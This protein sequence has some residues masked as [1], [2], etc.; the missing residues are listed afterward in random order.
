MKR[1]TTLN[2]AL[3]A[4]PNVIVE[5]ATPLRSGRRTIEAVAH[6]LDDRSAF[7]AAMDRLGASND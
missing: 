1:R 5:L 4:Y 3:I 7:V 2:L 6:R